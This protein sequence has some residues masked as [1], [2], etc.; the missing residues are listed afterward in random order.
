[1]HRA[2]GLLH[3]MTYI[4]HDGGAVD[5]RLVLGEETLPVNVGDEVSLHHSGTI[6]CIACDRVT[7]KSYSQG[8]CFPCSQRLARCDLCI[9]KP[10]TCHY[11]L[12]TCREPEWGE[13]NC[14]QPHI[15][16]FA[17]TSGLKVGITRQSQIPTRWVD[18]GASAALPIM[19]VSTR[20]QAG[21]AEVIFKQHVADR[22]DWRRLLKADSDPVDL[23]S[24]RDALLA[25]C[26]QEIEALRATYP[27]QIELLTG[28]TVTQL[29]FPVAKHPIKVSSFNLDKTPEV[30]GRVQGILGQYLI[31]ENGVINLRKYTGY[32]IEAT[33]RH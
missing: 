12:G 15:V 28:E 24:R 2:K 6:R 8:Y 16:Y 3:K 20:L 29:A 9:V 31:F 27:G 10:E 7:K 17:D 23:I 13:A 11:H 33:I 22:T 4:L 26:G 5:Y 30:S 21:L 1:M 32:E 19:K 14:M 25:E 18:Q